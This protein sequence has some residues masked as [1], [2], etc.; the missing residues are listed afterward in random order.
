MTKYITLL[1]PIFFIFITIMS[2][3]GSGNSNLSNDNASDKNEYAHLTGIDSPVDLAIRS[4][5]QD[6]K[7]DYWFATDGDGVCRKQ[8]NTFTWYTEK[9]GLCS[10]Y[11]RTIQEDKGGN[12]WFATREGFCKYDGKTFT[13]FPENEILHD[14]PGNGLQNIAGSFWLGARDGAY[15]SIDG[16][17]FTFLPL[18]IDDADIKLHN[19]PSGSN[20][21]AY[22]V[23]CIVEGADGI[24]WFGTEQRGVC[25]YS[26]ITGEFNW[27]REK[28]LGDGA[29]RCMMQDKNRNMWFGN[30]GG[31]V[32]CYNTTTKTLTNFTAFRGLSKPE[33]STGLEDETQLL[34]R[35]WSMVEDNEGNLWFATID[36]GI[37]FYDTSSPINPNARS[38]Y[39]FTVKD[40]LPV[41]SVWTIYKDKSGDLWFGSDGGGVFYYNAYTRSFANFA[42]PAG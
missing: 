4:I 24:I 33:L 8:G 22:A 41:N 20:R 26:T 15:H 42:L 13:K 35:A 27:L 18:P 6:S 14:I 38:L 3:N 23:Y 37:W 34:N 40:G 28:G 39:H 31:G 12:I 36:E 32:Y 16:H 7:G 25:Y 5:F 29:V 10:N 19:S 2:C 21:S 30:N 1:C 17:S 9:D 11:V